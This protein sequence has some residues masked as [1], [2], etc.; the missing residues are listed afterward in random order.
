MEFKIGSQYTRKEIYRNYFNQDL[1]MRG[2]GNWF[3]GYVRV[4]N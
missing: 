1:E 4:D 3:S 2:S